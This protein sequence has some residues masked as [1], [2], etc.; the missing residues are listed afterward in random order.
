MYVCMYFSTKYPDSVYEQKDAAVF[1]VERVF[2]RSKFLTKYSHHC[3]RRRNVVV[4]SARFR[5]TFAVFPIYIFPRFALTLAFDSIGDQLLAR[6]SPISV[7]SG[8]WT[9]HGIN[10]Y[11]DKALS[12]PR[13]IVRATRM[14]SVGQPKQTC[15]SSFRLL[16]KK[17]STPFSPS[18]V[19]RRPIV[20][21]SP[22]KNR[23]N[24]YRR[25]HENITDGGQ[26]REREERGWRG[27]SSDLIAP[28]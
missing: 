6:N 12:V 8:Q 18:F 17:S 7:Y 28:R 21:P 14:R 25:V 10:D 2:R 11:L 5:D 13:I 1:F 15:H 19:F 16:A 20:A 26:W 22:I 23:K 3:S 27:G 9:T 4:G 24:N